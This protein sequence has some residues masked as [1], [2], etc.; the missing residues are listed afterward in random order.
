MNIVKMSQVQG[1]AGQLHLE[2]L[3]ASI[4]PKA[5][6]PVRGLMISKTVVSDQWKSR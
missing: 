3:A 4:V 6:L 2:K 1:R 5:E